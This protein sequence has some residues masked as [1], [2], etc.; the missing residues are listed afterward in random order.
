M[1]L[2]C[3]RQNAITPET[4]GPVLRR[5]CSCGGSCASCQERDRDK[6]VRRAPDAGSTRNGRDFSRVPARSGTRLRIGPADDHFEREADRIA[7]RVVAGGSASPGLAAPRRVQRE[8]EESFEGEETADATVSVA[9][10]D[11]EDEG[12]EEEAE[13]ELGEAGDEDEIYDDP[14]GQPKLADGAPRSGGRVQLPIA[15]TGGAPLDTGVRATM[16][17]R[18]GHDFSRVRVHTGDD[19]VHAAESIHARAFTVGP[20]IYFRAGAYQPSSLVGQHLLAHELTH[21]VQQDAGGPTGIAQRQPERRRPRQRQRQRPPQRRQRRARAERRCTVKKPGGGTRPGKKP[22]GPSGCDGTC[23]S[24][25]NRFAHN[26]CCGNETCPGSPAINP[27]FFIRHLD[28]NLATQQTTAEWGTAGR[29]LAVGSFLTSPNPTAT[30]LGS[31]T[32]EAKC[33]A[34]HTNA[35]GEG[36]AWLAAFADGIRFG[37]HDSQRVGRGVRSHGCVRV[38]P[39]ACAKEIHDNTSSGVTSVCVHN[40]AHC[41]R[42]QLSLG[43]RDPRHRSVCGPL[44]LVAPPSSSPAPGGTQRQGTPT[45]APARQRPPEASIGDGGDAVAIAGRGFGREDEEV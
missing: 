9:E 22:C 45:Q 28:V 34:C 25:I 19:A 5:A 10:E 15:S 2:G 31:H 3:T 13:D 42:S 21:V 38:A 20:D 6:V 24:P 17:E 26:P 39:C 30:P 27:S 18:I 40:G 35:D 44:R 12:E 29:T 16:E 41:G 14:T 23:S 32:I 43:R 37:F 33:G 7:D 4:T 8:M 1:T 36:M 11:L